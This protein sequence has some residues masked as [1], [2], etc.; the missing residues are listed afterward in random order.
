MSI[1]RGDELADTIAVLEFFSWIET[2][3][4]LQKIVEI[5]SAVLI[6]YGVSSCPNHWILGQRR[7]Y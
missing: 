1:K 7:V 5:A 2:C 3:D 6:A 4:L